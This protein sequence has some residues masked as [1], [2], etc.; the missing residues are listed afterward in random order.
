M[1]KLILTISLFTFINVINFQL[2]A[3]EVLYNGI[4]LPEEWP[5]A[6]K[7][8][9]MQ[10]PHYLLSPPGI[11]P[12]DIGRQ[13]FV[14][15]FL[16]ESTTL[17]RTF[18][19]GEQYTGNP[20]LRPD[21]SWEQG[22]VVSQERG[23][24]GGTVPEAKPF[25]D[26]VWYDPDD[27]LF[28][29]WYMAGSYPRETCF[30]TSKNGIHWDKSE[31]DVVSGTNIVLPT[32]GDRRDS[33]TMW[34]DLNEKD[35]QQRYKMWQVM[36]YG[37]GMSDSK[38]NYYVS[39]DGIHW[40]RKAS[41]ENRLRGE[42]TT[43]FYNPFRKLWVY[44]IR[45]NGGGRH[46]DYQEDADPMRGTR[47][48]EVH[49]TPWILADSLDP[50]P[51]G[52]ACQ[53]Y[54]L[55]CVAYESLILG[56]FAIWRGDPRIDPEKM[57]RYFTDVCLGF[58]RD[59]FHWT[60][61]DRRAFSALS[62][63]ESDWNWNNVQS[64]GGGCLVMGD[65]LYFY[66][67]GA[68]ARTSLSTHVGPGYTGLVTLRRDGFASMDAAS[69]AGTLTTRPVHF[70]GKHMFVNV[71]CDGGQLQAEVLDA[72]NEV[73]AP[74]SKDNCVPIEVDKTLEAVRWQGGGDLSSLAGK[75]VKFRF[76][77][78]NGQLYSFWVSPT[79]NGESHGYVAAG[80]PGF[81]EPQD[82]AGKSAYDEAKEID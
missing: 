4:V 20:V 75:T 22:N 6:E 63:K 25:S 78:S 43:V 15:D 34:L 72:Q 57:P 37:S 32:D 55:D 64:V 61:P 13:L 40:L 67:S 8:D 17:K 24:V 47:E 5:P 58:T 28:K 30:A 66:L 31:L 77:L 48:I 16:I 39:G 79:P 38:F 65:K 70:S 71:D 26:G 62:E 81:T 7:S 12:I 46:R 29:M 41:S 1:A 11:I 19:M 21:R 76:Y 10:P 23:D 54:N 33:H 27:H 2:R 74:F 52:V 73:I 44:S 56:M 36:H 82:T 50:S 59:G 35:P 9:P 80:G 60:R 68:A 53:I 51:Q 3:Q 42:R 69:T 45:N 14:D 49:A 18:H